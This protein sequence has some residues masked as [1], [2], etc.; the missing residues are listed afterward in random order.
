MSTL[1]KV[2]SSSFPIRTEEIYYVKFLSLPHI[3][4]V[5]VTFPMTVTNHLSKA[6]EGMRGSLCLES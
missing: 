1:I 3:L 2:V 4:T 5:L 6:S